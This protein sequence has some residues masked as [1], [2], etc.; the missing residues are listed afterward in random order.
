MTKPAEAIVRRPGT[1]SEHYRR[2]R[3]TTVDL[4]RD[5]QPEDTVVQ[6]MPDVSPTKWHLA[7]VTWFFECFVLKT[8]KPGYRA[9]DDAFHYFFNSY[10]NTAGTMHPR[11]RRGELS[12]PTLARILDYRQHVDGA[13]QALFESDLAGDEVNRLV[14][15]G[16]HHEQ[17]HQEL[18]LT[19]IKHVL[20][21]NPLQ[22]AAREELQQPLSTSPDAYGFTPG[23]T[24]IVA[25]GADGDGFC[26]DNET[27]RHDAL[28]HPHALGNRLVTN[29]EYREFIN[30]GAYRDAP[31]WLSDGW[32]LINERGWNRPLYWDEALETEF[33]LGGRTEIDDNAPVCH[34]SYY[35]AD[36]FARWSGCRLPT[37]FEWEHAAT[38]VAVEGNLLGSGAWNPVAA[39]EADQFFGDVWEWTSSA[40]APYPGFQPLDGSLGEY[41]G[42]FMCNQMTVRGGSCVT[43]DDHIRASYRSFFYPDARWQFLG[44]RLAKDGHV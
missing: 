44:L 28:L 6:T 24:G 22:P 3:A 31:L 42:K 7:H 14:T 30:S 32:A 15:L 35:E 39:K 20:S 26:F 33:T 23:A 13:I 37:E 8:H 41:N 12:R 38:A 2:V 11:A 19:D 27:P 36:A 1:L 5:L 4:I 25:I 17:Q 29:G 43:A 21:C 10:Y 9:F 40:Y 34:I 18:L 16:L